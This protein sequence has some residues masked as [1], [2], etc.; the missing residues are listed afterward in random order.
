MRA[1]DLIINKMIEISD[2][3]IYQNLSEDEIAKKM[4]IQYF[5]GVIEFSEKADDVPSDERIM[6]HYYFEFD[7]YETEIAFLE[8]KFHLAMSIF[9]RFN[10]PK[11]PF[12]SG[13]RKPIGYQ[14]DPSSISL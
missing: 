9:S 2:G 12:Y 10:F 5:F 3:K 7:D 4:R 14:V 6:I 8:S 1:E 13:Y 11:K